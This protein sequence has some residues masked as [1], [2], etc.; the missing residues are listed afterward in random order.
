MLTEMLTHTHLPGLSSVD[1]MHLLAIADTLSHFSS[2]QIDRLAQ[3]NAQMQPVVPSVLGDATG[4][5]A[6]ATGKWISYLLNLN[7]SFFH[8]LKWYCLQNFWIP[9]IFRFF[10]RRRNSGRMRSAISDGHETAR[11][12][13]ALSP[14]QTE[15]RVEGRNLMDSMKLFQD[16][17]ISKIKNILIFIFL[18][19]QKKKTIDL[20]I[21]TWICRKAVSP[22]RT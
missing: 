1:Q 14:L 12:P 19:L 13:A 3:A 8:S 9:E 16:L 20:S 10:S 5:Y 22:R 11:I 2:D 17:P 4:G 18:L 15:N 21:Y 7:K 6:T